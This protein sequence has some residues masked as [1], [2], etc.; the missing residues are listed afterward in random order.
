[1]VALGL[2]PAFG[3]TGRGGLLRDMD[4]VEEAYGW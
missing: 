3:A 4:A 1:M 2:N